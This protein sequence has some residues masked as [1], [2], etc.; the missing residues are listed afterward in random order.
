MNEITDYLTDDHEHCDRL[1]ADAEN[2]VAAGQWERAASLFDDLM[3]DTLR[4]FRR[5]EEVLFPEFEATTG[6]VGGPTRVMADEHI[7]MRNTLEGMAA[8]VAGRDTQAYLGLSETLLMLMQQH[9]MKEER[10][11]YPMADQALADGP[12]TVARMRGMAD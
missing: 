2:A 5:E 9:N 10:I 12:G 6:M 11:L 3:R 7:Q 4:H 1:F 8:A